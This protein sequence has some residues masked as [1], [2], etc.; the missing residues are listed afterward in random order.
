MGRLMLLRRQFLQHRFLWFTAIY[1][2][3][4]V[5]FALVTSLV[6]ALLRWVI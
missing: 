2:V 4:L 5:A 1:V 3:S 6:R